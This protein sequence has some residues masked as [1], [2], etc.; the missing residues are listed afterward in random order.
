MLYGSVVMFLAGGNRKDKARDMARGFLVVSL[1]DAEPALT[2]PSREERGKKETR[3]EPRYRGG[4][5]I[6]IQT[7]V[8][9]S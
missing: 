4:N 1:P 3:G 7:T 9:D 5:K 6:D 8:Q 2:R